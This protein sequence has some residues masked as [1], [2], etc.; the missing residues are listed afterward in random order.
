MNEDFP[1][2]DDIRKLAIFK[3]FVTGEKIDTEH[4][5]TIR[6]SGFIFDVATLRRIRK[7]DNGK[8]VYDPQ[9]DK[10]ELVF[11]TKTELM[12]ELSLPAVERLSC[13]YENQQLAAARG[14]DAYEKKDKLE[15]I[16][17]KNEIIGGENE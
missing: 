9:A 4:K 7:D 6:P 2:N 16:L 10:D 11:K 1:A 5:L 3:Y 17:R 14:F 12:T 13:P 8:V 15:R